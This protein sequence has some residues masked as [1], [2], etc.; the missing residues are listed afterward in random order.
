MRPYYLLAA[1]SF[2]LSTG[3]VHA[4]TPESYFPDQDVAHFLV[5]H[6]DLATFRNS[7]Q[8]R[9]TTMDRTF[10]DLGIEPS[11]VSETKVELETDDWVYSITILR[12][13]DINRDG[14][15]DLE[16]CF[17]D[18]AKQGTYLATEP[19]LLTRYSSSDY[20]VALDW[21]MNGCE[22]YPQ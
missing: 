6:L 2:F 10:T 22:R 20:V 9:R 18:E 19:L 17:G 1:A 3:S 5:D 13:G 11:F 7:L 15:E 16:V 14:I 8:P 4:V 12:R 21:E